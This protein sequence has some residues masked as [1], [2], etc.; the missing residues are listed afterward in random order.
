MYA[1]VTQIYVASHTLRELVV[2]DPPYTL[3]GTIFAVIGI[4]ALALGYFV[5]LFVRPEMSR[6][7]K[8]L[9]WLLPLLIA[10]P[11]L[12]IAFGSS[13]VMTTV[14]VSN[15]TGMLSVRKT[16]LSIPRDTRQY[17]LKEVRS[18]NVGVADVSR[19]LYVSLTDGR[20]EDLLGA[21]DRT[22]YSE[23]SDAINTF[24]AASRD[25]R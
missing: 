18:V 23:V 16:V 20:S 13:L 5:L 3:L 9:M 12:I 25:R 6:P 19:F 4:V 15:D 24:L 8:V 1:P 10:S 11:F 17:P 22:G 14:T 2:V 21:T 7:L